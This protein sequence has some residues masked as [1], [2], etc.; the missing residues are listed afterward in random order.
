MLAEVVAALPQ[1]ITA[2]VSDAQPSIRKAVASTLPNKPHQ[3]QSLPL[4]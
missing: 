3:R 2:V 4:L 1:T